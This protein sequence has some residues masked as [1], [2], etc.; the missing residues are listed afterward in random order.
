V[1]D[2]F[3]GRAK[4]SAGYADDGESLFKAQQL[5]RPRIA[6]RQNGRAGAN[7]RSIGRR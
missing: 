1:Y 6:R 5:S 2:Y 7:R 3:A 4:S